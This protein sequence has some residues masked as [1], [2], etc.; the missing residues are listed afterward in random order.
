MVGNTPLIK[1]NR[2]GAEFAG[3]EIYGKAE[4][5]NPSGSVK[6][7]AA[8]NMIRRGESSGTLTHE[9]T[10]VD[11]TSGNTGIALAMFGAA[12]GYRVRIYMPSNASGERKKMIAAF[13][14]ELTLT[15]PLEG[16]DGAQREVKKLVRENPAKY[17]YSD[18]YNNPANWEAHYDGTAE[19]IIRQTNGTV[20]HFVAG[21]GTS[22]T[23]VGTARRLKEFRSSIQC[24][25]MQPDS[26]LHGLEGLKHMQSAVVP[27]IYDASI[28]DTTLEVS[29]E[30]AH[31]MMKRLAKEEGLFLGISSGANLAAAL[32][33]ATTITSGVIVTVL[34]D[35][36]SRYL[37]EDIWE[38]HA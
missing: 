18:Q 6:D 24:I 19:E 14:A 26:P 11:A 30:E 16:T 33:I 28:A 37:S 5:Q 34:C 9:K 13:G 25:S 36:G 8:L 7:R 38:E 35:D 29:T 27:G 21:L 10:I 4:W 17:F 3:V 23:F 2:I 32:K 1:M 12:L 15:N 31:A 20:T 22:G